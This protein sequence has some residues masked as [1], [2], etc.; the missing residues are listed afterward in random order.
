MMPHTA[1][2]S[3][4]SNEGD[5]VENIKRATNYLND[6]DVHVIHSSSFYRTEPQGRKDVPWY[7]NVVLEIETKYNPQE[8]LQY[9]MN[10]ESVLGRKRTGILH[11]PRSIDIDILLYDDIKLDT[12]LLSLPH[13]RMCERAF[14]LIPLY[15]I[16]PHILIHGK[17][18]QEHLDALSYTVEHD[19][20]RQ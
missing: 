2:L 14:V 7:C 11:E 1:Y 5:T 10:I 12:E 9:T 17:P 4:G 8:L 6:S 13:L 3:L 19:V 18:L 20:I 15:E 16:A